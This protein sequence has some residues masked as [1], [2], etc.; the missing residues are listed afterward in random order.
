MNDIVILTP[1]YNRAKTLP[2][3]YESLKNQKNNNFDWLVVDDGSNDETRSV[4]DKFI[5]ENLIN[6]IYIYQPNGG[7]ARALNTGFSKYEYTSVFMVVDSDDYLLPTA[8][9]YVYEY[10][11]KYEQN[12]EVGGF[13]FHY[14]TPDGKLLNYSGK[15]ISKDE[16]LTR[17]EYNNKYKQNDGCVCYFSRS[18]QKYRY[19]EFEGEK[20]VGPT[21]IQMEMSDEYKFVFSPKVV[22]VAEYLEGGL[23]K[24]GRKLRLKNP[25]GMIYYSK[26]MMSPKAG[27]ITQIKYAISI[28]PYARIANISIF[29]ILKSVNGKSLLLI[30]Y[31]PGALLYFKW[32]RLMNNT[33]SD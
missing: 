33:N 4:I 30:S 24:S 10:I 22:G 1:T 2:K 21:V 27:L 3:L 18:L 7:K 32:K 5:D 12:K 14:N 20:Y 26:L 13:F 28:W 17:Y 19:P 31:L 29:E 6:I 11:K 8:T 23:S 16:L 15:V 9:D 25:L